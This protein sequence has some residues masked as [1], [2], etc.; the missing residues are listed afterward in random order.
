MAKASI[1]MQEVDIE[2][3]KSE[4]YI[5]MPVFNL[6]TDRLFAFENK[7]WSIRWSMDQVHKGGPWGLV[8][9]ARQHG[10]R[11]ILVSLHSTSVKLH[12]TLASLN[13]TLVS[14]QLAYIR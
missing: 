1:R 7:G 13:S 5:L 8:Q 6:Y 4:F 12:G 2:C 14:L 9:I 10:M 3:H 11:A